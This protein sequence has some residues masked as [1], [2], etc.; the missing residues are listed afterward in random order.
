MSRA[1]TSAG[2]GRRR[3]ARRRSTSSPRTSRSAGRARGPPGGAP[4]AVAGREPARAGAVLAVGSD[5]GR[6]VVV[7]RLDVRTAGMPAQIDEIDLGRCLGEVLLDVELLEI[8]ERGVLLV[9]LRLDRE[10]K[11]L[12]QPVVDPP[13]VPGDGL[14]ADPLGDAQAVEDL[15][16]ALGVRDPPR[17]NPAAPTEASR[18]RTTTGTPRRPRSSARVRPAR[19]APTITT[20]YVGT[21]GASSSAGRW[22]GCSTKRYDENVEVGSSPTVMMSRRDQWGVPQRSTVNDR[23]GSLTD[24]APFSQTPT[25]SRASRLPPLACAA[26]LDGV[27]LPV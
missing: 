16:R 20:G 27:R 4:G 1:R 7:I 8:P 18:S 5:R 15:E 17:G 13:L 6:D 19:P 3:R 25:G 22:K 21:S 11:D 26:D 23:C 9:R 10:M 14:G 24:H 12:V 2:R